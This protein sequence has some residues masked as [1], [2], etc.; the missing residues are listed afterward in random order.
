MKT[1]AMYSVLSACFIAALA[2]PAPAQGVQV[3]Q[4]VAPSPNS[5]SVIRQ[6]F[7]MDRVDGA[8]RAGGPLY[9]AVFDQGGVKFTPALGD[10]APTNQPLRFTLHTIRR[11]SQ[12]L[13][14][15]GAGAAVEARQ[16]GMVAGYPRGRGIAETYEARADGLKQNFT[17]ADPIGGEGDL[18]VE[19]RIV[20]GL[21]LAESASGGLRFSLPGV[22]GVQLGAVVGIA[23]D[24]ARV[25]GSTKWDG[26]VVRFSLPSSFVDAA[27]F[28]LVLD[29]M[30][31]AVGILSTSPA[32]DPDV[33]FDETHDQ[34]LVCWEHQ[35]SAADLDIRAQKVGLGGSLVASLIMVTNETGTEI[36]PA[37]ANVDVGSRFFVAYQ[38]SSSLF[39]PSNIR[40]R[41]VNGGS[42]TG[43][44]PIID[45]AATSANEVDPD[46][47]GDN[48]AVGGFLD[49]VTVVYSSPN[50]V[51]A[52]KVDASVNA[53]VAG[54]VVITAGATRSRPAISKTGG[55]AGRHL[56]VYETDFG[57]DRDVSAVLVDRD[58]NILT[59][60]IG[61]ENLAS[62]DSFR[63]D[64]GGNGSEWLIVYQRS[65]VGSSGPCDI[66]C[67]RVVWNGSSAVPSGGEVAVEALPGKDEREPAV[68]D[69]GTKFVASWARQNS[70]INYDIV[71]VELHRETCQTCGALMGVL[72]SAGALVDFNPVI[73]TRYSGRAS[74]LGDPNFD[75]GMIAWMDA[76][77]T[78]PFFGDIK[79]NLY[80]A[81]GGGVV[82]DLGGACGN[83]GTN[84]FEGPVAIG[85]EGLVLEVAGAGSDLLLCSIMFAN[86]VTS[87]GPCQIQSDEGSFLF[88]PGW[89]GFSSLVLPVPCDASLFG[90][91]LYT[92]W[93]SVLSGASP[94]GLLPAN[95]EISVSNRLRA[96]LTP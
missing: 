77:I 13:Y 16:Q 82:T 70:S 46:C 81:F 20:T 3:D 69:L 14:E 59:S 26:E 67:R 48:S 63:P 33:A 27:A 96:T 9:K 53:V 47:G 34:F 39:G 41:G 28:P 56:V 71:A 61:I 2:A 79:A 22:G 90:V 7:G 45:V 73:A 54:P 74:N 49:G 29:P 68:G 1:T 92:Q 85:N 55:A 6:S 43:M 93:A 75:E 42:G 83:G 4:D 84:S 31:S 5:V 95:L 24:G 38:D 72:G 10:R 37:V 65:E 76:S 52:V 57:T 8:L 18:V 30:I 88:A 21:P 32:K 12:V 36:N 44:S 60:F 11:G 94:C 80:E 35:F 58:L 91:T 25:A 89:G 40:G 87:C 51:Q 66:Y 19:G 50:G 86:S 64:V 17:F 78:P 23:A 62:L 15:A